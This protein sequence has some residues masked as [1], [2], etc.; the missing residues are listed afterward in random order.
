MGG[1]RSAWPPDSSSLHVS[2]WTLL[3]F[4]TRCRWLGSHRDG[5]HGHFIQMSWLLKSEPLE[6]ATKYSLRMD[7]GQSIPPWAPRSSPTE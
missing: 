1:T 5:P 6:L 4:V 7:K 3:G 2:E